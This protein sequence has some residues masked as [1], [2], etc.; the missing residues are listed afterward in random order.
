MS[1][2]ILAKAMESALNLDATLKAYNFACRCNLEGDNQEA[3]AC[4][5]LVEIQCPEGTVIY[6]TDERSGGAASEENWIFRVY[7]YRVFVFKHRTGHSNRAEMIG[8]VKNTSIFDF[9]DDVR[10]AICTYL[11]TAQT[12]QTYSAGDLLNTPE[13]EGGNADLR[14]NFILKVSEQIETTKA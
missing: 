8:D 9:A 6:D 14:L 4:S 10:N 1:Y 5:F 7:N 13:T 2:S 3:P 12:Y 11:E